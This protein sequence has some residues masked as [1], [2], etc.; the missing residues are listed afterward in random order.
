MTKTVA[1]SALKA[2]RLRL[3]DDV[4]RVENFDTGVVWEAQGR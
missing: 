3:V 2:H 4:A 1:I